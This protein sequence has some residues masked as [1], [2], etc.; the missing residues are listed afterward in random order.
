MVDQCRCAEYHVGTGRD[1]IL[2]SREPTNKMSRKI[3]DIFKSVLQNIL[4]SNL[5]RLFWKLKKD[6]SSVFFYDIAAG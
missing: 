3:Q 4:F 5:L 6:N 2:L 1:Y